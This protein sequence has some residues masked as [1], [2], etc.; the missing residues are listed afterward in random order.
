M[1]Q[2]SNVRKGNSNH[3]KQL[4]Q[5]ITSLFSYGMA[6]R[7]PDSFKEKKGPKHKLHC[8]Q[9]LLIVDD[10]SGRGATSFCNRVVPVREVLV[11]VMCGAGSERLLNRSC[12]TCMSVQALERDAF[13]GLNGIRT[14]NTY[15]SVLTLWRRCGASRSRS[16]QRQTTC[17]KVVHL[18]VCI[19]VQRKSTHTPHDMHTHTQHTNTAQ[20][21]HRTNL[22][23]F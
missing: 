2:N 1:Q 22:Q 7:L 9:I 11:Q 13:R 21:L 14:S 10:K 3:G 17:A 6:A 4:T 20:Y 16:K 23:G 12:N 8:L 19:C 5:Y 18:C 15:V